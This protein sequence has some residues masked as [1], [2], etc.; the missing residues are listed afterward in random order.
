MIFIFSEKTCII[1][2]I[3]SK[4]CII[5][6]LIICIKEVAQSTRQFFLL[7]FVKP[8]KIKIHIFE[9]ETPNQVEYRECADTGARTVD[10]TILGTSV[11]NSDLDFGYTGLKVEDFSLLEGGHFFFDLY[12]KT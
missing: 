10:M 8:R 4:C 3:T 11:S 12:F 6:T 9:E 5:C 2:T 7:K 1:A